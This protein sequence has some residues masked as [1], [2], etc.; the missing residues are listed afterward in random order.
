M[1]QTAD[2]LFIPFDDKSGIFMQFDGFENLKPEDPKGACKRYTGEEPFEAL[3]IVKQSDVIMLMYLFR[4]LFPIDVVRANWDY[5]VPKT[6]HNS[7]LSSCTHSIIASLLGL[8]EEAYDF[9]VT[10]AG[11]DLREYRSD[12]E[13]GVHAASMGGTWKAVVFGFGGVTFLEDK[14]RVEPSLPR[15]WQ[16]LRIPLN[17]HGV[18]FTLDIRESCFQVTNN[19]HEGNLTIESGDTECVIA[20]RRTETLSIPKA[21]P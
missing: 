16:R 12:T 21:P 18:S 7:S 10:S 1:K 4:S 20:P 8:E 14:V 6:E 17:W 15:K 19:N 13:H 11:A 2:K 5:Y 9:F 3:Q